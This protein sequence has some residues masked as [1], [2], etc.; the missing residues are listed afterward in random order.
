MI[1]QEIERDREVLKEIVEEV[2]EPEKPKKPTIQ[3]RMYSRLLI[4][5]GDIGDEFE[6][7]WADGGDPKVFKA[8]SYFAEN[9]MLHCTSF[10][11]VMTQNKV[12]LS[13]G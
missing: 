11:L 6:K 13:M 4:I 8:Y 3:D 10:V 9:I 1:K 2:K 12:L 7:V 5:M